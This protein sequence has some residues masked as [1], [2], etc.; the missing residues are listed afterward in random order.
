[1]KNISICIASTF[2]LLAFTSTGLHAQ[3]ARP[4]AIK[5]NILGVPPPGLKSMKVSGK[6]AINLPSVNRNKEAIYWFSEAPFSPG[7]SFVDST[8]PKKL[9]ASILGRLVSMDMNGDFAERPLP[10]STGISSPFSTNDVERSTEYGSGYIFTI[11]ESKI[12]DLTSSANIEADMKKLVGDA[13]VTD[14]LLDSLRTTLYAGYSKLDS[15]SVKIVG[16]YEV[17]QLSDEVLVKLGK[18]S[19][20][21]FFDCQNY[22]GSRKSRGENEGIVTSIGFVIFDVEYNQNAG[23]SLILN[24]NNILSRKGLNI[25][26]KLIIN[27]RIKSNIDASVN[28]G[29]QVLAWKKVPLDALKLEP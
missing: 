1:M 27:N 25:N 26:P 15:I 29:Y 6:K 23:D 3:R 20:G 5:W 9:A 18:P 4:R 8:D 14:L 7:Q 2:I 13:K 24:I 19:Q 22:W 17:Y 21:Y 28:R 10:C 11:K 16:K 12:K